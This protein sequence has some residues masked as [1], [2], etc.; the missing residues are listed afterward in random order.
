M[1]RNFCTQSSLWLL[2]LLTLLLFSLVFTYTAAINAFD[3]QYFNI[4]LYDDALK[5]FRPYRITLNRILNDLGWHLTFETRRLCFSLSA[6]LHSI[7]ISIAVLI[8]CICFWLLL[9]PIYR[10]SWDSDNRPMLMSFSMTLNHENLP[11]WKL[12]TA[13]KRNTCYTTMVKRYPAK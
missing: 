3:V 5:F 6:F 10:I 7:W 13:K 1:G 8:I 4:Y 2:W 11:K 9:L 12:K